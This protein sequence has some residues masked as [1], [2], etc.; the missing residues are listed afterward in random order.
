MSKV[1]R[2]TVDLSAYP[3]LV[4]IYLG[5]RVNAW[6]GL[7]TLLGL[8]PKIAQ[9]VEQQPDGLLRHENLLF[10]LFPPHVGMRQYWRDFESLERWARSEPHRQWWQQF[11]RHSGGTGFWHETYCMQGGMEAVYDDL[12][13]DIGF[14]TFAPQ[15]VARGKMYSARSRMQ[16]G[17]DGNTPNPVAEDELYRDQP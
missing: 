6:T 4:V 17:A 8:G 1:H 5:L 16:K 10:S 13:T 11:M 15:C 14:L 3:D 7:K 2:R 9:A 12:P